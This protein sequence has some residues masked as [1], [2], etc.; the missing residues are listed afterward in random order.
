M[1][2]RF[3]ACSRR[4]KATSW[5]SNAWPGAEAVLVIREEGRIR[6]LASPSLEGRLVLDPE[7]VRRTGADLRFAA[8]GGSL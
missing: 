4:Q 3:A 7:F 2:G 5:R 8:W 6:V 1:T